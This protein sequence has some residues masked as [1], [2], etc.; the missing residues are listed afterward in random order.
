MIRLL[1]MLVLLLPTAAVA[2]VT[3]ETCAPFYQ[4]LNAVPHES[5]FQQDGLFVSQGFE[6]GVNGC[7]VVMVTDEVRLAGQALP[8]LSA[9]PGAP[10]F[11]AGWNPDSSYLADAPGTGVTGLE[12]DGILCLVYTEQQ[13]YISDSG[14]IAENRSVRSRVECL[15]VEQAGCPQDVMCEEKGQQ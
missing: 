7:M 10:M 5:I 12:K 15:D 2:E 14:K 1:L 8:D 3:P 13:P 11:M 4:A 6:I 9:E